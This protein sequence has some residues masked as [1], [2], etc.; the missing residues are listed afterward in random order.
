[1]HDNL[2]IV[3][4]LTIGLALASLA[5]Y[6]ARRAGFPAVL[7]YLLAGYVIGPYS[8]GFVADVSVAEQ[9]AELGVLLMLFAVGLHFKLEDLINVK[10]VAIPGSIFQTFVATILTM[11]VVHFFGGTLIMGV[12]MGLSVGVAS[13][14]VLVRILNDNQLLNSKEGH[15]AIGWL[16]VEDIVTVFILV[17]LPSIANFYTN[18]SGSLLT[19]FGLTAFV[20]FKFVILGLFMFTWGHQ[21]VDFVLINVARLRSQELFGLTV[22]SLMFVIATGSAFVFGTSIALGA[23]IAGM[24]IGKTKVRYQ[25]SVNALPLKDIFSVVFFL[26]VG[27][28]FNPTAIHGHYGIF[29]SLLLVILIAKPVAAYAITRFFGYS[30]KVSFTVAISLAQIGEFSFILSEQA[31]NLSLIP[32]EAFDL[33]VASSLVSVSLNPFWFQMIDYFDR[34]FSFSRETRSTVNKIE[35]IK[36]PFKS[37]VLIIGYGPVGRRVAQ[38]AKN[39]GFKPVV[40]ESNVDTVSGLD[41]SVEILFGDA[42]EPMILKDA[43]VEEAAYLVITIPDTAKAISVIQA[44]RHVR[45]S[46]EIVTRISYIQDKN[47]VLP[48]K[49]HYVCS[50]QEILNEMSQ[51]VTLLFQ[52]H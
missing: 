39:A 14:I 24:V 52:K 19:I 27:M 35:Q 3:L 43:R 9:L 25:A 42:T 49:V 40:I 34:K 46:I 8:P 4:I 20:I 15:I 1:M 29:F 22:L 38:L 26:S 5:G 11:G 12:L 2:A 36:G 16:V 41:E 30:F 17:L 37:E 13:T 6:V 28:L 50:E 51:L 47:L 44:A 48:L 21:L 32:D 18:G 10:N 33:L 45:P 23:F 7:G 31:M